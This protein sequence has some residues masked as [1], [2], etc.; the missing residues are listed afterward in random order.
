VPR[1]SSRPPAE[2]RLARRQR[3]GRGLLAALA[4]L[5]L[6]GLAPV[7]PLAPPEAR[8]Q[9][10]ADE[11]DLLF[12]RGGALFRAGKTEEAILAFLASNRLARNKNA[13]FNIGLCFERLAQPAEA[14]RFFSEYEKEKLTDGE[15]QTVRQHLAGIRPRVAL[16][17]V[18]S[19]PP[20]A[21][22][23]LDRRDLGARGA[24]PSSYALPP[25]PHVVIVD[26]AGHIEQQR[27]VELK[28][29]HTVTLEVA[30]QRLL[31]SVAIAGSPRG[32]TVRVDRDHGPAAGTLPARLELNPGRHALYVSQEGFRPA[33]TDVEVQPG[34]PVQVEVTLERL[35]AAPGK[36]FVTADQRGALVA[37]DGQPM[38]VTPVL[39]DVSAGQHRVEITAE[40]FAPFV[41][42]VT[43]PPGART[44]VQARLRVA[45]EA[46]VAV[47]SKMVQPVE[48]APGSITTITADEI[49]AFGYRTLGQVLRGVR[50]FYLSDDRMYEAVGVR[51]FGPPG[52]NNTRVLVL[53]NGHSM[54]DIW[55]GAAFV[56]HDF[57]AD[58]D[59]VE[60]VQVV[61]GPGSALYG[62]GAFFG[63]VDVTTRRELER[64]FELGL[65]AGG[66]GEAFG[67]ASGAWAFGP[68]SGARL[69]TS[70]LYS[71]RG[72][73]F[74]D[75]VSGT[76]IVDNDGERAVTGSGE[77]RLG[78]LTLS[79]FYNDRKKLL[80]T[81]A[82]GIVAGT[83]R[84]FTHDERGYFEARYDRSLLGRLDLTARAYYDH[85]GYSGRW[86][87]AAVASADVPDVRDAGGADWFG[88]EARAVWSV[89]R[90]L[91]LVG[92]L[93]GLYA[94]RVHQEARSGDE[95][96]LDDDRSFGVASGYALAEWRPFRPFVL[97]GGL[98]LDYYSTS[99]LAVSPRVAAVL[100]PY[101]RGTTKVLFGRAFRAPSIYELYYHDGGVSEIPSPKLGPE[102]IYTVEVEHTHA[103]GR[104]FF[105][106]VAGYYNDVRNLIQLD[107]VTAG[108]IASGVTCQT[109]AGCVQYA[110]RGH[111]GTLGGEVELRRTWGPGG[112][113]AVAYAFQH[114][115]DL[116]AGPFVG[117]HA[118]RLVNSP[119]HLAFVRYGRPLIA[120]L[121][122]LGAELEYGSPRLRRDGTETSHMLLANL[123]LSGRF[124][125]PGLSW[126]FS[127]QN[128]FDWRYGAPVG[129]EYN[130]AQLQ[131][132][133]AGRTYLLKIQAQF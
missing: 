28:L 34:R 71:P 112:S 67:R 3:P 114:S 76:A 19:T 98:R 116:Q 89:L 29:G 127:V 124:R 56:G 44:F 22:V 43:V 12:R 57:A 47:A 108:A 123:T 117:A 41:R 132:A 51:G 107:Q 50:G 24:T 91:R 54:N 94:P 38:G 80:P 125:D 104:R 120:R 15:R 58:L 84:A 1:L 6:A 131:V 11:A 5:V 20:G 55:A 48:E 37:V 87:Y 75:P 45:S 110:N 46:E 8:A 68:R 97:S 65:G 39:L 126:S 86:P 21:T 90:S 25:G 74:T 73:S 133:Q 113:L 62:T 103:F 36:L 52:D 82:F 35:P 32:A 109:A 88:L 4:L 99:G 27:T 2:I 42:F 128:L 83:G 79:G 13:L 77:V 122:V 100:H 31:G 63:V 61:R 81:T 85:S 69:G 33:R 111:V 10:V 53:R 70:V 96:S 16:I 18:V 129:E 106:T 101:S 118:T 49:Q 17:A 40:D 115:R 93:E 78:D 64:R 59:D 23:Y 102:T 92:G 9:G 14:Y 95:V 130:A 26:A 30:L 72:G 66:L 119:E 105:L 7:G 121:L 60:R